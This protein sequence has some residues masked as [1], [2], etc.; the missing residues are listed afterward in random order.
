MLKTAGALLNDGY[1]ITCRGKGSQ[2]PMRGRAMTPMEVGEASFAWMHHRVFCSAGRR[3]F[4]F[5]V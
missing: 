5:A 2:P 1:P 3:G 4:Y